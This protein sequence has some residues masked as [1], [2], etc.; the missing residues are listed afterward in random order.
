MTKPF[1]VA[2][3]EQRVSVASAGGESGKKPIG[4][5]RSSLW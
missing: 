5:R 1:G 3:L 2:E 4:D